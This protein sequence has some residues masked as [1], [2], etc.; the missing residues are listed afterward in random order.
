MY[1]I[2]TK[3]RDFLTKSLRNEINM[4][5]ICTSNVSYGSGEMVSGATGGEFGTTRNSCEFLPCAETTAC[6][7]THA[8]SRSKLFKRQISRVLCSDAS[9]VISSVGV[10]EM[11]A[12]LS[13]L[14]LK[15][16]RTSGNG[17][18]VKSV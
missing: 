15:T 10:S 11:I 6:L 9:V 8:Q 7:L 17:K 18:Y 16:T 12:V 5:R 1:A 14:T 3:L 4:C 2:E 13:Q